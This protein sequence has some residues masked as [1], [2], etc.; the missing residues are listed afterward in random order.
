MSRKASSN[1]VINIDNEKAFSF[2][3]YSITRNV[4][5]Q[6]ELEQVAGYDRH[7]DSRKKFK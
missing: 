1:N 3:P 4:M 2:V 7:K 5:K 6:D